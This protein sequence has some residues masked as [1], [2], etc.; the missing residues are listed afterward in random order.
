[1]HGELTGD[2][3]TSRDSFST[4]VRSDHGREKES[5]SVASGPLMAPPFSTVLVANRGEIA[6][7]V[8]RACRELGIRAVAVHS[9]AD[10]GARHVRLADETV[11]LAGNTAAE[12][13]L[14]RAQ[15]VAAVRASGADAVHPGYGFL[16]EDA[17]FAR[18]VADAGAVFIG[19]PP[20]AI[21]MMGDKL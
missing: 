7:R 17:A 10:A 13:Y 20:E 4:W 6:V 2:P 16:A 12:S 3:A 18:A 5:R 21:E 8:I 1:R 9:E 15:L 11:A 14:D 19:P